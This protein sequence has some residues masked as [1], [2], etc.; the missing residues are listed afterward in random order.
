MPRNITVTFADGSTHVY[1]NAPDNVSPDQVSARAAKEFGKSVKALDGGRGAAPAP[2]GPKQYPG[3]QS[4]QALD[5]YTKAR[6]GLLKTLSGR[7]EAEQKRALTRFDAD[8]RIRGIRKAAGLAEVRTKQEELKDIGRRQFEESRARRKNDIIPDWMQ[9]EFVDS[10]RSSVANT[11]GIGDR[12]AALPASL[13]SGRSYSDELEILREQG[14]LERGQSKSAVAGDIA[15]MLYGGAGVTK[16]VQGVANVAERSAKP[17][18]QKAGNVLQNLTNLKKGQRVRNVGKMALGGAAGGGAQAIGEGSDV[19]TGVVTG[20]IGAPVITGAGKAAVATGK[21]IRNT[22]GFEPVEQII[23]RYI[24]TPVS[25]IAAAMAK[26]Q[27]Q[28][29]NSTIYEVLPLQDRQ[30]LDDAIARMPAKARERVASLVN[31][32]ASEMV[33]ETS[34][35][36]QQIIRPT[37]PEKI[38]SQIAADLAKSR[39][40]LPTADDIALAE[41]AARSPLEMREVR[42]QESSNIMKPYDKLPAFNSVSDLVPQ[43]PENVDGTIIMRETNPEIGATIRRAANV[44]R[45]KEDALTFSDVT[46]IMSHLSK[47][48]GRGGIEGDA[49]ATALNHISDVIAE[50]HPKV[51][52]AIT[53]MREVYAARRR[54]GEGV[55]EGARTRRRVDVDESTPG[56]ARKALNAY[57]TPEGTA[58][59]ALGQAQQLERDLLASPKQSLRALEDIANNPTQRLAI[60]ENLGNNAGEN[61]AEVA[62]MQ[63][64]SARRL[65]G[66]DRETAERGGSS[67]DLMQNLMMLG[68]ST[69]PVTKIRAVTN[70][71]EGTLR[72]PEK[73]A[74]QLSDMLFSTN[75]A[76]ISRAINAISKYGNEGGKLIRSIGLEVGLGGALAS[77]MPESNPVSDVVDPIASDIPAETDMAQGEIDPN[78]PYADQ[79]T[80]VYQS[81]SP[82]LLD[83]IDRVSQQE[84]GGQ[85]FDENGNVIQSPA[86]AIGV[87]QV[88]P[89]TAPEAARLAG[90]PWDENAYY[91]DP[92]YNKLLGIAYL[93]EMLNRFDGDVEK[94]LAAYNA[95]PGRLEQALAQ[96]E[97]NWLDLMPAETQNYVVSIL[98]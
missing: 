66:L 76:Q 65:S 9:P 57:D 86:G 19:S 11:F 40:E 39:G 77:N 88:M 67:L 3:L 90:L 60:S 31:R 58:G 26:R 75:P 79:L 64:Q 1:Q 44:L 50:Q 74:Q 53:K 37:G 15:G 97:E 95:G 63:S 83:L 38:R 92:N 82:E 22:A 16:G 62:R 17:A 68:P 14:R 42:R 70:L 56:A 10:F 32:R 59:R 24:T 94:A 52:P 2:K 47:Q 36:V 27:K 43:A 20:A 72:I 91:N 21:F 18:L 41:R 78:S 34:G 51:A 8:P 29:L 30:A 33:T 45:I 12:I 87:M 6:D 25:E 46:K 28:G 13:I 35:R 48:Q 4:S 69:L 81:E 55:T 71:I 5:T 80:Q 54:M 49:A 85:H 96:N 73:Q 98:S 93:S 61:I 89:E 7:S 23:G 84:S